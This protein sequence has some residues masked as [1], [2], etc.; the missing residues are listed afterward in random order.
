MKKKTRR[1][2][3]GKELKKKFNI[4]D[5]KELHADAKERTLILQ[6]LFHGN[7]VKTFGLDK[8]LGQSYNRN[9]VYS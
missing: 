5:T 2:S 9:L 7:W 6:K 8:T 3:D 4:S 1:K